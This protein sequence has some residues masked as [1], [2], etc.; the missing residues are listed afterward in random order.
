MRALAL[1]LFL[2][3]VA[4]EASGGGSSGAEFLR[5]GMGARPAALGESFTGLADDVTAAAWNPA[6]L[7]RL[8][9]IELSAMHM[10]YVADMSYE[11]LAASMPLGNAGTVALSGAYLNVPPFDSTEPGSGLPK[12]SAGDGVASLSWGMS[13]APFMP[14]DPDYEHLFVGMTGKFI[15]RSLGGYAP[16]GGTGETYTAMSGA[17]DLGFLYEWTPTVTVG[18]SMMNLGKPVTFLGDE[19]DALPLSVRGGVGWHALDG[20]LFGLVLLADLV[21]PV[22]ADGGAFKSGT[23]GGAGVE[24]VVGRILSLR[25]GFRQS[26]DG[27]RV[28]GGAGVSWAGF[29]LDY[30]FLPMEAMGTVHRMGLTVKIG[31]GYV[32]LPAPGKLVGEPMPGGKALVRWEPVKN[33]S[34]YL[35]ELKKPGQADYKRITPRPRAA[36]EVPLGGLKVGEEYGFRVLAVDGAGHEGRPATGTVRLPARSVLH[37][38]ATFTAAATGDGKVTLSWQAVPGVVGY[39]LYERKA[40]GKFRKLTKTP[41]K[42]IRVGLKGLVPGDKTFAVVAVDAKGK[43]SKARAAKV[44]VR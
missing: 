11:F 41:L 40:D 30:A 10:M 21:K 13:L 28:V 6:G 39:H 37:P 34:G 4:A 38:P 23:W 32:P 2:L 42:G 12:G 16:A 5:I 8:K 29:S 17:A 26:A 9:R 22:D 19:A 33:A 36:P 14:S 35:V 31:R 15:Y 27:A 25:G 18:A 24:A 1:L 43:A 3:P 20:K 7:G 44:T